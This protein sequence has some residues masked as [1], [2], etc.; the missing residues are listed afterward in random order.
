MK[1]GVSGAAARTGAAWGVPGETRGRSWLARGV[2]EGQKCYGRA[3]LHVNACPQPEDYAASGIITHH[4]GEFRCRE[5]RH[6]ARSRHAVL[7][8]AVVRH[9]G[10]AR[11]HRAGRAAGARG[12]PRAAKRHAAA[13][14]RAVPPAR[15]ARG[16]PH[17]RARPTARLVARGSRTVLGRDGGD[18]HLLAPARTAG[19][20]SLAGAQRSPGAR[21]A[22]ARRQ[23]A[24]GAPRAGRAAAG[25]TAERA[26][27]PRAAHC[28]RA[29]ARRA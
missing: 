21:A 20:G 24:R 16:R 9:R 7:A 2:A 13:C 14:G 11:G 1:N 8:R 5:Q 22:R 27:A 19:A 26:H 25:V 4:R 29:R 17:R 18:H 12:S 10:A 3:L 28:A 23:R 6:H 15:R